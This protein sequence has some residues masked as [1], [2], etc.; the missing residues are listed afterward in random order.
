M[1]NML[2]SL[3]DIEPNDAVERLIRLKPLSVQLMYQMYAS[4]S[5]LPQPAAPCDRLVIGFPCFVAPRV[6]GYHTGAAG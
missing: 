1:S 5:R 2:S 3:G 4:P 6:I